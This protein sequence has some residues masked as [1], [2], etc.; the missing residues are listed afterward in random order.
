MREWFISEVMIPANI[1]QFT[2]KIEVLEVKTRYGDGYKIH[3]ANG[4]VNIVCENIVLNGAG[5]VTAYSDPV[6]VTANLRD[7][8]NAKGVG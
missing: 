6:I 5:V 3:A 7:W 2:Y 8:L 4:L 1:A